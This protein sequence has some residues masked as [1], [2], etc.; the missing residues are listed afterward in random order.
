MLV[1]VCNAKEQSQ[2]VAVQKN[3]KQKTTPCRDQKHSHTEKK[4]Y[5]ILVSVIIKLYKQQSGNEA[6]WVC[7]ISTGHCH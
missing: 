2:N 4:N 6:Q 7:E 1:H 3:K 5:S